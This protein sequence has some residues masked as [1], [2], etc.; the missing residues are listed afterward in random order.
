MGGSYEPRP[1]KPLQLDTAGLGTPLADHSA[2]EAEAG[3][4]GDVAF[5]A[6]SETEAAELGTGEA[7][8][9]TS[10]PASAPEPIQPEPV[11]VAQIQEELVQEEPVHE[12]PVHE[13][14]AAEELAR[15]E[16]AVI[17][18]VSIKLPAIGS[19]APE[20]L[21]SES[22]PAEL[23]TDAVEASASLLGALTGAGLVTF[24]G[25][26]LILSGLGAAWMAC[27][28]IGLAD[29]YL[30]RLGGPGRSRAA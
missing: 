25:G 14:P 17:P 29:Q 16:P 10:T 15:S 4:V 19:L 20:S 11:Q 28:S 27:Y 5:E 26:G 8:E 1:I 23:P 6:D 12:D 18:T 2:V 30:K 24:V 7:P 22:L 9:V 21:Q 13:E 3:L